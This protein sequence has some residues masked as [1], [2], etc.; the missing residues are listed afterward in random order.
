M[1]KGDRLGHAIASGIEPLD[2]SRTKRRNIYLPKQD[3][4]DNLIWMLYRSLELNIEIDSNYRA[5]MQEEAR[6]VLTEVYYSGKSNDAKEMMNRQPMEMLDMYYDSWKLRGDH[7][8]LYKSGGYIRENIFSTNPYNC[9]KESGDF[10]LNYRNNETIAHLYYLYHFDHEVKKRSMRVASFGVK[11]WYVDLVREF[12][13]ALRKEVAK[14]GIAIEC[15]PTSNILIGTFQD[16]DK[17]PILAFNNYL[18]EDDI[19][20]AHIQVSVNTDDIGVFDTSLEHEYALLLCA[21][22]R[23]RHKEGN[24][25]DDAVY[26]Y[27]DYLREN[28]IRMAFKKCENKN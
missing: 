23:A 13:K 10:S 14:R 25:N 27:L 2:Y 22:C 28:G 1:K 24:Y 8:D 5:K 16:Y 17:H 18:L 15:N 20:N 21:I 12:Q 4:L 26:G 11:D 3:Y 9:C 19:E 7:P 6:R